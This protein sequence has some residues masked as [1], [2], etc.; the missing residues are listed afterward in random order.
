MSHLTFV[1]QSNNCLYI[2][3]DTV[4]WFQTP[5]KSFLKIG[6]KLELFLL[7]CLF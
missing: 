3:L 1:S 2:K 7:F 6:A 5:K 4:K